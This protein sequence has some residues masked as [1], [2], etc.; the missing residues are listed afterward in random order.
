MTDELRTQLELIAD[1]GNYAPTG[2]I[3]HFKLAPGNYYL[4]LDAEQIYEGIE[5]YDFFFNE[6]CYFFLTNY[7]IHRVREC[8]VDELS[9]LELLAREAEPADHTGTLPKHPT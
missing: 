2:R 8:S 3:A 4:S 1:Q 5:A 6:N 9:A 7:A